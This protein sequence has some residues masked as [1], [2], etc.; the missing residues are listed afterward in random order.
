MQNHNLLRLIEA[1]HSYSRRMKS[2]T[3]YGRGETVRGGY[4]ITVEIGS[5]NR[6]SGEVAVSLPRELDAL[7]SQ[8]R[9]EVLRRVARGRLNV[10]V[11]LQST[12]GF[13]PVQVRV[14]QELARTYHREFDKLNKSL[15]LNTPVSLDTILKAPGVLESNTEEQDAEKFWPLLKSALKKAMEGLVEMRA[16]EGAH[17]GKD[18]QTRVKNIRA[19]VKRITK[20]A[21]RVPKRYREQLLNRLR[22]AGIENFDPSDERVLKEIVIFTDRTD[23]TEELTRLES[24]FQQYTDCIKSND[25]V[26]RKLDFLCQEMN[27]EVNTIGSKA[28]DADISKEVVGAKTELEK[29]REQVQN[30]E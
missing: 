14:N 19:G 3:G 2:M 18:L 21:P 23:I 10:R 1:V 28:Q 6:K 7:E 24:H 26:G 12:D 11:A 20:L 15:K 25:P 22:N 16:T 9:D 30:V 4:K 29:F 27:R 5:V 17:L 8:V 13:K